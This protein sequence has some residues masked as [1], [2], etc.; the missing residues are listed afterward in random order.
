[1]RRVPAV[2]AGLV[3]ALF[4]MADGALA[5]IGTPVPGATLNAT[6]SR[7]AFDVPYP[8]SVTSTDVLV[9]ELV[10]NGGAVTPPAGWTQVYAPTISNPRGW[11]GY[12]RAS[13]TESGSLRVTTQSTTGVAKMWKVSG[14]NLTTPLTATSTSVQ[15]TSA[16]DSTVDI[17][18][19]T[20]SVSGALLF[21]TGGANS[22]AVTFTGPLGSNE[23][24]DSAQAGAT[25]K[26][27]F[28]YYQAQSAAGASGAKRVTLSSARAQWGAMLALR[29]AATSGWSLVFSD[30]FNGTAVDT[31]KWSLYNTPGHAG[32]GLRRPSQISVDGAGNLVITAQARVDPADGKL[33][34]W[35][36][37]MAA[38]FSST[39]GAFETRV[40]T[41]NDPSGTMSGIVMTWPDGN[42][43]QLNG[44][45]DFYETGRN[46]TRTP[47]YSYLHYPNCATV[48]QTRLIHDADASQWH[49]M[50]M[51]WSPSRIDVFRDG[52][53]AG[54]ITDPAKITDAAHHVTV[55]LDTRTTTPLPSPVRQYVDYVRVYRKN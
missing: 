31:N 4:A 34:T 18:S 2:M 14:V 19:T 37:A 53:L 27:A 5:A 26:S 42:D 33:K 52:V 22:G 48:C 3:V 23:A 36:G 30:E 12:K 39:Y 6:T 15:A 25:A 50:R 51:E 35:S 45:L 20:T 24:I 9:V 29:P 49:V 43:N 46:T 16:T 11:F 1:M 17:P 55:Q 38:R 28:A 47:F 44:E 41:E 40:R 10:T 21:M 54:S 13:G 32:N 8:P 7:T